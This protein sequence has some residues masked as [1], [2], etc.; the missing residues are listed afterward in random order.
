MLLVQRVLETHQAE[1]DR[2]VAQV[3]GLGL[4]H[5]VVVD[6]DHVVEHAHCGA[7]GVLQLLQV[8]AVFVDVLGQVDRAQVAD[9][10]LV[11]VGVE[12]D[13]GAQVGGV[14]YP[15]ML[16]RRAQV[17]GILEGHPGVAGLEQHAQHL[18][19]QVFRLEGLEQFE[20]PVRVISSY[21]V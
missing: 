19:P 4:G 21:W 2:A 8:E 17:A 13:L 3:G 1:P 18:A 11:L 14:H 20:L 6:V 10:D 7:H 9:R 16:L 12:G 15:H 5:R